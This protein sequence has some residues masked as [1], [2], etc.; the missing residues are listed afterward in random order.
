MR[1]RRELADVGDAHVFRRHAT[2]RL[3][4]LG[5]MGVPATL[6]SIEFFVDV[7]CKTRTDRNLHRVLGGLVE[8]AQIPFIL[9]SGYYKWNS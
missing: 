5:T 1:C 4:E 8:R 9:I 7:G 6:S 2:Q 3:A